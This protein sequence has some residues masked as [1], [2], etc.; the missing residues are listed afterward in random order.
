MRHPRRSATRRRRGVAMVLI[1]V[2]VATATIVA[3]A[4][5]ASRDNSAMI[6][7]RVATTSASRWDAESGLAL[8]TAILQT[9]A[10]WRNL[11]AGGTLLDGFDLGGSTLRIDLLDLERNAPPDDETRWLRVTS[12]VSLPTGTA[13]TAVAVVDVEPLLPTV[14]VDLGDFAIFGASGVRVRGDGI[15]AP[16]AAGGAPTGRGLALGTRATVA[17]AVQVTDTA[18]VTD[19]RLVHAAATDGVL[20]LTSTD[21]PALRLQR[22]SDAPPLPAVPAPPIAAPDPMSPAP[23]I[24]LSAMTHALDGDFRSGPLTLFGKAVLQV[25]DGATL[26]VESDLVISDAELVFPRG[27]R[28]IVFGTITLLPGAR[29]VGGTDRDLVIMVGDR[30]H[31]HGGYIGAASVEAADIS[32]AGDLPW[33]ASSRRL[34]TSITGY[35]PATASWLIEAAGVVSA[36]IHAPTRDVRLVTGGT[37]YGRIAA[38]DVE[39]GAG[40]SLFYDRALDRGIGPAAVGG[41]AYASASSLRPAVRELTEYSIAALDHLSSTE[42]LVVRA[43]GAR[44]NAATLEV[45]TL[46]PFDVSPSPRVR[47][48]TTHST[49]AAPTM[50]DLALLASLPRVIIADVAPAPDDGAPSEQD[51]CDGTSTSNDDGGLLQKTIRN[52]GDVTKTTLKTVLLGGP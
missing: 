37:V 51:G 48:V 23:P 25:R 28:L 26:I 6:G 15:V 22:I 2:S 29:L 16:W 49:A 31:V 44:S 8:A 38:Q 46:S 19:A 36:Q 43:L 7:E 21:S 12:T 33:S 32:T 1:L 24:T 47:R 10:D 20:A 13:H 30:V 5:L 9:Q 3:T 50:A 17:G 14:Q 18:V 52:A 4:Y 34:I 11:H 27:G 45:P 39:V 40:G 35:G 41:A 42:S